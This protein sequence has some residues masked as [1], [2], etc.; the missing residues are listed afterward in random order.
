MLTFD[1]EMEEITAFEIGGRYIFKTY[2]E[3][4][5]LFK[6][7]EKYYNEDK[8]R[9]KIPEYDLEEVRQVIEEYYY[10]LDVEHSVEDYCVVVDRKSKSASTLKNSVMKIHRE[11]HE[12][13]VMKDELSKEQSLE[14]GAVTLEKSEAG[15]EELEWRPR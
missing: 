4:D 5:Q 6:E 8:Y 9:F 15:N 11:Q 12:I 14:M 13:L 10:E 3:E 2:F 1:I 7:L